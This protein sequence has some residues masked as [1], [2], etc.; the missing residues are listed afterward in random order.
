MYVLKVV[1]IMYTVLSIEVAFSHLTFAIQ[2]LFFK[3]P[4]S[5]ASLCCTLF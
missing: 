4:Y 5:Q 2:Q 3:V 1:V